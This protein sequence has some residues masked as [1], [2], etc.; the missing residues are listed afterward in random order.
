M[1]SYRLIHL[2]ALKMITYLVTLLSYKV[3]ILF[4]TEKQWL[5]KESIKLKWD[6]EWS[7]STLNGKSHSVK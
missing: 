7:Q 6:L 1:N 3:K 2:A 5:K 4:L